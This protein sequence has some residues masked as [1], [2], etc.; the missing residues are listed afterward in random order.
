MD[1]KPRLELWALGVCLLAC[2][3]AGGLGSIFISPD[4]GDWYAKLHKPG[5]N[6]PDWV[7]APVWTALYIM[8]AVA[9][10]IIW[11]Q[12]TT[13]PTTVAICLFGIQLALNAAWSSIFFGLHQPL[14]ALVDL[15]MLWV[16]LIATLVGFGRISRTAGR[17]LLP[18][19]AWV[20]FA[21][22]LNAAI[23]ALN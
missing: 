11:R 4:V 13:R 3:A 2:L 10:W 18:Y 8:M 20:S 17:L 9:V 5:F 22:V 21:G 14:M 7:F 19:L 6:P 23:V 16:V 1:N 15:A 12:R